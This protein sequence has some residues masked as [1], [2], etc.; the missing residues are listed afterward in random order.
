MRSGTEGPT[1]SRPGT[2]RLALPRPK[3]K[4]A[5]GNG[6]ANG[7]APGESPLEERKLLEILTALRKGNFTPRLRV[8][9]SGD[10]GR[11]ADTVN[12]LMDMQQRY[13]REI[14]RLARLVGT[15]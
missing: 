7:R 6:H 12:E 4:L 10:A 2:P 1:P 14:E 13:V 8:K 15:E 9:W 3:A 5:N 11:I